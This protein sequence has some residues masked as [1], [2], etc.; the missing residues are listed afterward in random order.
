MYV[1]RIDRPKQALEDYHPNGTRMTVELDYH[2]M[3]L[4]EHALCSYK[5]QGKIKT[6]EQG[7]LK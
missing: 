5:E 6:K 3:I 2:E 7:L 1:L 4:L